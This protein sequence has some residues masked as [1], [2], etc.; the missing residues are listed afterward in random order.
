[1]T[2]IAKRFEK[3]RA[4]WTEFDLW[5]ENYALQLPPRYEVKILEVAFMQDFIAGNFDTMVEKMCP[6]ADEELRP[7]FDIEDPRAKA[8]NSDTLQTFVRTFVHNR[9]EVLVLKGGAAIE[10]FA[11]S[12]S[13]T[14]ARWSGPSLTS[15]GASRSSASSRGTPQSAGRSMSGLERR[16]RW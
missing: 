4:K 15:E 8:V 16:T 1:M 6:L 2:A 10:N 7:I 13:T 11:S 3:V 12:F 5:P 14:T 9:W